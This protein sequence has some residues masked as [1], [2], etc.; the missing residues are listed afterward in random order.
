[1]DILWMKRVCLCISQPSVRILSFTPPSPLLRKLK[2]EEGAV[3]LAT[4]SRDTSVI[5]LIRRRLDYADLGMN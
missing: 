4:L 2:I 1:V 3:A 5:T